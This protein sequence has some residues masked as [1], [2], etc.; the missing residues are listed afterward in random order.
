[1]TT[2][3]QFRRSLQ[4]F[5][6]FG[7]DLIGS[8]MNTFDDSLNVF[9]DFCEHDPVFSSIHQQLL[10]VRNVD[11]DQ[12]YL[13]RMATVGSMAGSG[14]LSLPTD[15]EKRMAL[16]YE[17]LR[18]IRRKEFDVVNFSLNFFALNTSKID[19]Y[20]RAFNDAIT[21]P[22]IRELTYR[23]EDASD[24]LPA[25]SSESVPATTIQII[26]QA[27]NVIQQ[28]AVGNN[29]TQT[30]SNSENPE[31]IRLFDQLEEVIRAQ[32]SSAEVL[33]EQL[34]II[35]SARDHATS[36]N[37]KRSVV[38]ALLGA[39]PTAGNVLSIASSIVSMLPP[40]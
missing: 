8:D 25:E 21:R 36:D 20:V 29:I 34:E 32:T 24:H 18:R 3:G 37:P 35:A 27:T 30:A 10:S 19:P 33:R 26:H 28:S 15:P 6:D 4:R 23:L 39:L 22:L 5:S 31:L 14:S 11:F 38:K 40:M 2:A 17:L 16:I 13:S 12:W 9:L 7:G 1:M